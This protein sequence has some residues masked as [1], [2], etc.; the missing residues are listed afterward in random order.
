MISKERM[1]VEIIKGFVYAISSSDD[2][3]AQQLI[4]REET[5]SWRKGWRLGRVAMVKAKLDA[6][7][8]ICDIAD[9]A[10][11]KDKKEKEI[12]ES[13]ENLL[14]DGDELNRDEILAWVSSD[15]DALKKGQK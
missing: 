10:P 4:Y 11:T 3:A 9:I 1:E 2:M 15:L 12:I 5:F 7:A 8:Y 14:K 6:R 13:L